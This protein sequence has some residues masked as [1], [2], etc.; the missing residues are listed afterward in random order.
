MET[1]VPDI[2]IP[3]ADC[4]LLASTRNRYNVGVEDDLG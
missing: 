3:L 4:K 1:L 2:L